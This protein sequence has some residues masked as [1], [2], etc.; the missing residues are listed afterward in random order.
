MTFYIDGTETTEQEA[1]DLVREFSLEAY[2]PNGFD[3]AEYFAECVLRELHVEG[4][5]DLGG[6]ALEVVA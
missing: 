2:I 3:S 4:Y 5:A 1:R 6:V